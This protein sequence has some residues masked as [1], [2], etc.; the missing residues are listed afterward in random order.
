MKFQKTGLLRTKISADWF[1][2]LQL[3]LYRYRSFH[4]I[5][6]DHRFNYQP[7]DHPKIR[8]YHQKQFQL[9]R[10]FQHHLKG[11]DIAGGLRFIIPE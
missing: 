1:K 2:I 7:Q 8:A 9:S 5:T 6:R 3:S 10:R 4:Q 11:C